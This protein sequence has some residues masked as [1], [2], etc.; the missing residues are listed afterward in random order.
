[1]AEVIPL[2]NKPAAPQD[3]ASFVASQTS[4]ILVQDMTI[5]E[6]V[7]QYSDV[8]LI[9][10]RVKQNFSFLSNSKSNPLSLRKILRRCTNSLIPHRNN[11]Y[12]YEQIHQST[13]S[14]LTINEFNFEQTSSTNAVTIKDPKATNRCGCCSCCC[15]CFS[16]CFK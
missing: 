1:M 16:S 15:S 5:S 14:L 10:N 11:Y 13:E 2:V 8:N 7:D 4:A 3:N 6:P 9:T 12:G